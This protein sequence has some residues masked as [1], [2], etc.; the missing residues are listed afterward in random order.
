MFRGL[1][2]A[3]L[4]V[5]RKQIRLAFNQK[6][7]QDLFITNG[8]N[9]IVINELYEN[10]TA[11]FGMIVNQSGFQTAIAVYTEKDKENSEGDRKII[12]KMLY[13]ILKQEKFFNDD[14]K[15]LTENILNGE[16]PN[17]YEE[18]FKEAS[19]ALKRAI[20][21]YD[22]VKQNDKHDR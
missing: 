10:Y 4:P 13:D 16:Y 8:K 14:F 22:I 19:I 12:I 18:L 3:L 2:D 21:T 7:S 11:A 20:R 6:N 9:E 1:S 17:H 5:A 15:V